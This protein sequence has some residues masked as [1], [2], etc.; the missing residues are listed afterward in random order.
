MWG[1]DCRANNY[2]TEA[3]KSK[4]SR[5]RRIMLEIAGEWKN[6]P[7]YAGMNSQYLLD[8]IFE[9]STEENFNGFHSMNG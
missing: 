8:D 6:D 9:L 3:V 4:L 7:D 5:D 1:A 2:N